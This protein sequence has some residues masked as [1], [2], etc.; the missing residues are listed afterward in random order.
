MEK[1]FAV[2]SGAWLGGG[3]WFL[4]LDKKYSYYPYLKF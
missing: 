3:G 4:I 1:R 2:L